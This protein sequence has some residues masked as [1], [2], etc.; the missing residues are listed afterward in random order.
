MKKLEILVYGAET[1]CAS[2]V[3]AP[4]SI[5][6]ASWL[7]AALRRRYDANQ[8]VVRYVDIYKPNSEEERKFAQRVIDE[9][10]WY[11]VV[12]V[13]DQII[14]EGNPQLKLVYQELENRGL[15]AI[16]IR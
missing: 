14:S 4:S 15:S 9:D 2:C 11:P 10:L 3:N 7:E 8:F 16:S 1:I 12:V 6:T 13:D 5:E